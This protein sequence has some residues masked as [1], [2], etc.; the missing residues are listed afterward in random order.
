MEATS[1]TSERLRARVVA[2]RGEIRSLVDLETNCELLFQTP[3]ALVPSRTGRVDPVGWTS[4][5]PG[6]WTLLF[7]NAGEP[8]VVDGRTHEFHG[9]ASLARWNLGRPSDDTVH[10]SWRDRSGLEVERRVR[11]RGSRLEVE[12]R[13]T[14]RAAAPQPYLLVEHLV[15][16]ERLAGPGA[17]I[18]APTAEVVR[19]DDSGEAIGDRQPWPTT[20]GWASAPA[21][22]FSR[23]GAL[24]KL[25]DSR[26]V[27]EREGLAVSVEWNGLSAV[28]FWHEHRASGGFPEELLVTCLGIEPASTITSQGLAR[29]IERGEAHVLAPAES[30]VTSAAVHVRTTDSSLGAAACTARDSE[31]RQALNNRVF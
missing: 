15:F 30:A 27:V 22:P 18:V 1:I 23:F 3:W 12:N 25:S 11:V 29:A 10:L 8:C 5:W 28:W 4:A 19:M 14:N 20:E 16:G 7:P 24:G 26:V 17:R 13:V 31:T 9:A 6:G 21:K 2:D